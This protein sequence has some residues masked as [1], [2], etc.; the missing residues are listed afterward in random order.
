MLDEGDLDAALIEFRK[1]VANPGLTGANAAAGAAGAARVCARMDRVDDAFLWLGR[2]VANGW[3]E[4]E[5]LAMDED[6]VLLAGDERY[7]S[8]LPP[9]LEG[10]AAFTGKVRILHEWKGELAGDQF[11]W[12]ARPMG[13]LDG[14]GAID[15]AATAPTWSAARGAVYVISSRSGEL[16]FRYKGTTPGL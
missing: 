9:L 8:V 1:A 16:L 5:Q 2:A 6:L 7:T 4:R 11:G 12:V 3:G 10:A 13:D 15:F 14:D